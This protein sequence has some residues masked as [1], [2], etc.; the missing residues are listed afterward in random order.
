MKKIIGFP[1]TYLF[2]FIGHVFSKLSFFRIKNTFVFD[3]K[4]LYWLGYGFG[5]IY[6]NSMIRSI[7]IQDWAGLKG[8]WIP[9]YKK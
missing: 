6:Q 4:Y 1:L 2:Y 5:W 3:M 8:P 9:I 7:K